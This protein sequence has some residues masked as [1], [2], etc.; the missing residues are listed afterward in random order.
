M[1]SPSTEVWCTDAAC[2]LIKIVGGND[3]KYSSIDQWFKEELKK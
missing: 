1:K 3:G 2:Y